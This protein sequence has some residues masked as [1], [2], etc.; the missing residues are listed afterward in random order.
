MSKYKQLRYCMI[1]A[2]ECGINEHPQKHMKDL[3]YKIIGSVPQSIADCWWF[4][5][6]EFIEPLP[7]YLSVIEY[8]FDKWHS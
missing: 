2:Y 7:P 1:T 3:G 4:T 8:N 5:V 6:E